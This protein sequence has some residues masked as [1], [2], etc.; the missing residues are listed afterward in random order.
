[1]FYSIKS[2]THST[3]GNTTTILL[4]ETIVQAY[5]VIDAL[6]ADNEKFQREFSVTLRS[7]EDINAEPTIVD[8]W[9]HESKLTQGYTKVEILT[10]IKIKKTVKRLNFQPTLI[11]ALGKIWS[12][13]PANINHNWLRTDK[14]YE[15]SL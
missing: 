12:I 10:A 1:M 6:I 15:F 4:S 11:V 5:R 8:A 13:F 2:V 14:P 3:R 7:Q 9:T